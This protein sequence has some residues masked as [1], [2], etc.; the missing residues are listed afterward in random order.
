MCLKER[1]LKSGLLNLRN[2]FIKA[3][4][5]KNQD[6][7]QEIID[8]TDFLDIEN[9]TISERI[10]YIL[11]DIDSKITCL[12]PD[13][14]NK[15]VFLSINKGYKKYCKPSCYN[16]HIKNYGTPQKVIDK[17]VLKGKLARESYTNEIKLSISKKKSLGRKNY[18]NSL[19]ESEKNIINNK[20][21]NTLKER[22]KNKPK[23]EK[24]N[25]YIKKTEE[26]KKVNKEKGNI[27]R[28]ATLNKLDKSI[29]IKGTLKSLE[30][31]KLNIL[32]NPEYYKESIIKRNKTL[33]ELLSKKDKTFFD[34]R[35]NK[36]NLT[37]IKNNSVEK[38]IKKREKNYLDK[39]GVT[40]Y[41]KNKEYM[42]KKIKDLFKKN[43]DNGRF[44]NKVIPLFD[45]NEYIG[46]KI[47]YNWKCCKCNNEFLSDIPNG[48]IPRCMNCYPPMTNT[49][50]VERELKE[51]LSNYVYIENNK[52]FTLEGFRYEIDIFIPDKNIGIELDGVY[53]HSEITG[54]KDKKYHINKNKF[55]EKLNIKL[56]HIWDIEWLNKQEIVKSLLLS[57]LGIYKERLYGRETIIKEISSKESNVFLN[58][59]H[60]QGKSQ[61]S[62]RLGLYYKEELVSVITFLRS[63][64]NKNYDYELIRFCNK[65]NYQI[66]GGF[67][68]LFNYYKIKYNYS[69]ICYAD[70]RYSFNLVYNSYLTYLNQSPP[71][72][73]YTKTHTE[74][75]SRI[76]YQKHKLKDKLDTFDNN[77][78][79]WENMVNNNYDRIWDCGNYVFNYKPTK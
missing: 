24:I 30:T 53:W 14:N 31:K 69:L 6:I 57:K 23:K 2:D 18:L 8:K 50:N 16:K 17:I 11:N 1:I 58:E 7:I 73:F 74:L 56:I 46:S 19:T 28:I 48:G 4:I 34:N 12:N 13:C 38:G 35:V 75:Y 26:E 63:R 64:F 32:N 65:L 3:N 55:F 40:H 33:K 76:Q 15:T 72:Y 20:I 10:Y 9:Y 51:F 67:S 79:E 70:I 60:L 66:V 41:T 43:L 62:I 37:K 44:K 27:K 36:A 54:K 61:S 71:N 39:Y 59:N 47:N 42:D 25:N 22:N 78:T 52:R 49:S 21:S 77:L 68:K 5:E 45:V 29:F